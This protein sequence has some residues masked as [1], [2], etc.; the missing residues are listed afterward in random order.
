MKR[1]RSHPLL[2]GWLAAILIWLLVW[3]AGGAQTLFYLCRGL[4]GTQELAPGDWTLSSLVETENPVTG[5]SGWLVSTDT[6][7]R[8]EWTGERFVST[9]TLT[10]SSLRP[11][12][13]VVLYYKTPSQTDYSVEQMVY[14]QKIG[15]DTYEFSLGGKYVTALRIDPA[16]N[17]AVF[18]K[19]GTAV[20]DRPGGWLRCLVPHGLQWMVLLAAGPVLAALWRLVDNKGYKTK[21]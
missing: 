1:I 10:L 8:M 13:A 12:G 3:C 11:T 7:P 17:G 6:D 16:S 15:E 18:L 20:I 2:A 9:V 14:A 4:A 5:E 19:P 21:E